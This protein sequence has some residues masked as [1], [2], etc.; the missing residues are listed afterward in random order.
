M[1]PWLRERYNLCMPPREELHKLIDSLPEGAMEAAHR[2]LSRLQDVTESNLS[3]AA[4]GG[5]VAG[6]ECQR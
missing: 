3:G 4:P 1:K 5:R 6:L 2:A